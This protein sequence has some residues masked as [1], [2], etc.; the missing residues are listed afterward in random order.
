MTYDLLAWPVDRAMSK[1]EAIVEI[2]ERT[3]TWRIGLGHDR[4]LDPFVAAMKHRFPGL[5]RGVSEVP[6]EFGVHRT[7]VFMGL[8]WSYVAGLIEVI[9]SIAFEAGMAL[10]DPQRDEVALPLPFGTEPLGTSGVEAHER[11]AERAFELI[12]QGLPVSA[13]DLPIVGPNANAR[14]AGFKVMSPLGFEITPDIEAEVLADPL[15]VPTKLQSPEGRAEVLRQLD[16]TRVEDRHRA[17][18][19]LGGWD[20][21]PDVRAALRPLLESDDVFV[22]GQACSALAHQRSVGDLPAMLVAVHRMS[23]AD[24]GTLE[25]MLMPLAATLE[26]AKRAGPE[27]V[28]DAKSKARG[29]AQSGS[30]RGHPSA[31]LEAALAEL[32]D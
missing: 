18:S 12:R 4:R 20:P 6:M 15:R 11:A 27:A 21:D 19:M 28:A 31:R 2:G 22:V 7:W 5:D 29:W 1:D 8:P 16:S 23:P 14:G 30:G 17:L 25:A 9:G 24:G 13:D 32:L 26:L 3:G 10:F